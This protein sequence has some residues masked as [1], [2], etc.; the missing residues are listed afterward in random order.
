MR[1]TGE[2]F[3]LSCGAKNK[4]RSKDYFER[5]EKL[6]QRAVFPYPLGL[7]FCFAK[8]MPARLLAVFQNNFLG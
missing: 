6:P 8:T 4:G 5:P 7:L 1:M 2:Q 3:P